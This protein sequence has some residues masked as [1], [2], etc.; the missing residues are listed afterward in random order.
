[1]KSCLKFCCEIL[2]LSIQ[3]TCK[4]INNGLFPD[5][6]AV[7]KVTTMTAISPTVYLSKFNFDKMDEWPQLWILVITENIEGIN[8]IFVS[9]WFLYTS[10]LQPWPMIV[11]DS[12]ERNWAV[13]KLPLCFRVSMGKSRIVRHSIPY[14]A[15][16]Q[17]GPLKMRPTH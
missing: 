2:L 4:L 16:Y 13:P 3:N 15:N 8:L 5:V 12:N 17:I 7:I 1:M 11:C 9:I 14:L 6:D 10:I